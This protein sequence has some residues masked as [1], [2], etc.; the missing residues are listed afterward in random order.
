MLAI[1]LKEWN[2]APALDEIT[3]QLVVINENE[4]RVPG[5]ELFDGVGNRLRIPRIQ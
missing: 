4:A 1:A 2:G 3:P 5:Y